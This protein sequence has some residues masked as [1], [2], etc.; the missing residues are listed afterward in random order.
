MFGPLQAPEAFGRA[1]ARKIVQVAGC[2][3]SQPGRPV[4]RPVR[5]YVVF[6]VPAAK[7][8]KNIHE[9]YD[10]RQ[11]H[12]SCRGTVLGKVRGLWL[13]LGFDSLTW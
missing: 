1:P 12:P 3:K 10:A 8:K 13:D 4:I 6:L 11:G 9:K 2:T 5:G 7:K